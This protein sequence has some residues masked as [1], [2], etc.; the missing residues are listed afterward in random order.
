MTD[1]THEAPERIWAVTEPN[2]I[3]ADI[4]GD[5]YAQQVPD[6]MVGTPVEYVRADLIKERSDEVQAAV[7]AAL[8]EAAKISDQWIGCEPIT[9]GILALITPDAQAALD[10]VKR[11]A[12]AK[13][14]DAGW[15]V[16]IASEQER[17]RP[18]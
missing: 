18:A 3:S 5:V 9:S 16:G 7:A 4:L 1:T 11:K 6:G 17:K 15:L 14:S 10:R 12:W 2:D 8:R 13:G